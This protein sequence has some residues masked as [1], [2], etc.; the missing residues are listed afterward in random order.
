M[1]AL[2]IQT[3]TGI[4]YS[5]KQKMFLIFLIVTIN[6]YF[7]LRIYTYYFQIRL[8]N[9]NHLL[10]YYV[11]SKLIIFLISRKEKFRGNG[12]KKLQSKFKFKGKRI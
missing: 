12:N 11:N 7:N 1:Q 9:Q 3:K 8:L 5:I 6:F 4:T 10:I 2:E